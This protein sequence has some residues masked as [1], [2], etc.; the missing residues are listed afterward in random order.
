MNYCF[1][2][3]SYDVILKERKTALEDQETI[4][5]SNTPDTRIPYEKVTKIQ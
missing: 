5:S 2:R 4:Q 1:Y 3:I